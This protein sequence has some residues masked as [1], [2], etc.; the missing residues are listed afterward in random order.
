MPEP[1]DGADWKEKYPLLCKPAPRRVRS[2]AGNSVLRVLALLI[3][4]FGVFAMN[5]INPRFQDKV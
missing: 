2:G 1:N 5:S 4:G 3:I